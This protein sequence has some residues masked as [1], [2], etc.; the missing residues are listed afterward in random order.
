[1]E[2]TFSDRGDPDGNV[3]TQVFCGDEASD[4][5]AEHSDLSHTHVEPEGQ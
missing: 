1:M 4:S 3:R 2:V 5:S